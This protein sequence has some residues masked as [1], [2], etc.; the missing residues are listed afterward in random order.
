MPNPLTFLDRPS[1]KYFCLCYDCYSVT[2]V[3]TWFT[4]NTVCAVTVH[5]CNLE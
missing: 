5:A 2:M 1:Y 3:T 4:I